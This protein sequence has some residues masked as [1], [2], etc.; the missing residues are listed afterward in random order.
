ME[1]NKRSIESFD[2]EIQ[3]IVYRTLIEHSKES[4]EYQSSEVTE[5]IKKFF[6]FIEADIYIKKGLKLQ[7]VKRGEINEGNA[8]NLYC[9][10]S[11]D[12]ACFMPEQG[13]NEGRMRCGNCGKYVL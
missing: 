7:L 11:K 1:K 8:D 6:K 4:P 13:K 5:N 3:A 10:C 12:P 9:R 2:S